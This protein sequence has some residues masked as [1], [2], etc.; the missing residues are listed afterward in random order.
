MRFSKADRKAIAEYQHQVRV[1]EDDWEGTRE[2]VYVCKRC[3][4]EF[5]RLDDLEVDHIRPRSRGGPDN[6]SN[7]QLL[8]TRCNR[9]KGSKV[10]GE[11]KAVTK[12]TGPA[13]RTRSTP[14][15]K[16]STT[17][18]PSGPVTRK[19]ST[20]NRTPSTAKKKTTTAKRV[21]R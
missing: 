10:R 19:T 6:P 9:L 18:R 16:D 12:K 1:Y 20:A 15:K 5:T 11:S 7:L 4:G 21:R 8:C 3:R 14:V 2:V 13:R 17:K